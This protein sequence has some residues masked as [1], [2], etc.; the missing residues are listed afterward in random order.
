MADLCAGATRGLLGKRSGSGRRSR[1]PRWLSAPRSTR[2]RSWGWTT[3]RPRNDIIEIA[4]DGLDHL[5]RNPL[6]L[7]FD[8]DPIG[9]TSLQVIDGDGVRQII[10]S[11]DPLMLPSPLRV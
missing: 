9:M 4:L 11:R 6:E 5:V 1:W 3:T 8:E 2:C 10:L 7:Y